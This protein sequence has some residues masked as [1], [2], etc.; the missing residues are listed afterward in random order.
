MRSL[1]EG[2]LLAA[3]TVILVLIMT[4]VPVAGVVA[5]V[6]I[7]TPTVVLVVRHGLR[8]AVAGSVVSGLLLFP[9]V[10]PIGAI[11]GW[12]QITGIGLPL[13]YGLRSRWHVWQIVL[14]T[15]VAFMLVSG[16]G[17]VA[18]VFVSGFN[19][20]E[21]MLS[22]YRESGEAAYDVYSRI[23]L[24][25]SELNDRG[26]FVNWWNGLVDMTVRLLPVGLTAAFAGYSL[27]TYGVNRAVLQRLGHDAPPLA[28]FARWE[29]PVWLLY[30]A[31]GVLLVIQGLIFLGVTVDAAVTQNL[32]L[33]VLIVFAVNGAATAY[34]FLD[35]WGV[36]RGLRITIL[37]AA[38]LFQIIVPLSW[39]GML[40]AGLKLRRRYIPQ[41]GGEEGEDHR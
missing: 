16:I 30:V 34:A 22:A 18:T 32:T 13:G 20:W 17:F 35:H 28:P 24:L 19:P 6:M 26:A 1:T 36:G 5:A 4:Y 40:D 23:G 11:L 39:L 31:V 21:L 33:A 14:V 29:L 8:T 10:G 25:P 27:L 15:T 7:T 2:A 9:F 41:H 12:L 38:L 37:V 3:L